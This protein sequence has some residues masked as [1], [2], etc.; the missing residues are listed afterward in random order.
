MILPSQQMSLVQSSRMGLMES[1]Q[2]AD[3]QGGLGST[4]SL[5]VSRT[6]Y[7]LE[8]GRLVISTGRLKLNGKPLPKR[9]RQ[10]GQLV[11]VVMG[12]MHL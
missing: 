12:M 11:P 4:Q 2:V 9:K 6:S 7:R 5:V 10:S 1:T 8:E 3:L